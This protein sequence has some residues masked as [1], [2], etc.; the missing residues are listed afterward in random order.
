V[1]SNE[2]PRQNDESLFVTVRIKLEGTWSSW[3]QSTPTEDDKYLNDPVVLNKQFFNTS[4]AFSIINFI[5]FFFIHTRY[6]NTQHFEQLSTDYT[7][8]ASTHSPSFSFMNRSGASR[9]TSSKTTVTANMDLESRLRRCESN[10]TPM[11]PEEAR[12]R[13]IYEEKAP[14]TLK[15]LVHGPVKRRPTPLNDP[16]IRDRLIDPKKLEEQIIALDF[17]LQLDHCLQSNYC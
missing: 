1:V 13:I 16:L 6:I 14:I 2:K 10:I 9:T 7:M 8:N 15:T 4:L 12:Q 5:V 17:R 11:T 3:S